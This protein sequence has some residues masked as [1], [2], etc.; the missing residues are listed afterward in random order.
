MSTDKTVVAEIQGAD[1]SQAQQQAQ[2]KTGVAKFLHNFWHRR[3]RYRQLVGIL[4]VFWFTLVGRPTVTL[5]AVG[6]AFLV[7]GML[8]RLWASGFVMKN[9]VL[10]TVGP[11]ARVRHP[12]YVGN[13]AIALGICLASGLWWSYPIMLVNLMYFYPHTIRY[14]DN[15]LRRFFPGEWDR[16][17]AQTKA[18]I[19]SAKPYASEKRDQQPSW[20]LGLSLMRNGEPLHIAVG[21]LCIAYLYYWRL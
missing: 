13:L 10:A 2:K 3:Q 15:K 14:E 6:S 1:P 7:L 12:L 18:L 9:E 19:P 21:V 11:Y 4:L 8:I 17:A 16:W 5:L 20:S